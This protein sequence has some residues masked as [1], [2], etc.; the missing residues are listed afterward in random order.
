MAAATADFLAALG[1]DSQVD[2]LGWSMGGEVALTML[3]DNPA[4]V[5]TVSVPTASARQPSSMRSSPPGS[6]PHPGPPPCP[7]QVVAASALPAFPGQVATPATTLPALL[8]NSSITPEDRAALLFPTATSDGGFRPAS[9]A[10]CGSRPDCLPALMPA[11][12]AHCLQAWP[13]RAPGC[14]NAPRC[15]TIRPT[16][17]RT[18]VC[19]RQ[20][21]NQARACMHMHAHASRARCRGLAAGPQPARLLCIQPPPGRHQSYPVYHGKGRPIC[22]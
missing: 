3:A 11:L 16:R 14:G 20:A 8:S 15:P 5:R 9:T 10:L 4:L 2:L 21:R 19:C 12:A 7:P 17:R 22:D 18:H 13:L 1:L 6:L